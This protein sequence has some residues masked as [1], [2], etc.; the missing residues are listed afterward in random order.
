VCAPA[1]FGALETARAAGDTT[2][3]GGIRR[4]AEQG[5]M[6]AHEVGNAVWY[7]I[8]TIADLESAV[9]LVGEPETA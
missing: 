6:R 5:L 7:D 8:D 4:L 3:S 1:L 9:A 2:L